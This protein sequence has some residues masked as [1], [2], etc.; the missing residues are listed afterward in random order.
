MSAE[1]TTTAAAKQ[2]STDSKQQ[3]AIDKHQGMF[4]AGSTDDL[5]VLR[6]AQVITC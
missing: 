5:Q 3:A 2:Q 1:T 6:E 4:S